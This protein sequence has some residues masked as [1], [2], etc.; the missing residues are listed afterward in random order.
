M[1][2]E[3]TWSTTQKNRIKD[4][5]EIESNKDNDI[6][7]N[8]RMYPLELYDDS[9]LVDMPIYNIDIGLVRFNFRNGRLAKFIAHHCMKNN[10]DDF[11]QSIPEHQKIIQGI[12]LNAKNY[13]QDKVASLE[14]NLL[15]AGQK[16]PALITT[17]GVLWNGNRRCAV[18]QKIFDDPPSSGIAPLVKD[19]IKVC[20]LPENYSNTQLRALEKRLQQTPETK[21]SYGQVNEMVRIQETINKYVE[22]GMDLDNP[23][24]EQKK[25]IGQEA[26]TD[27]FD[28]WK[29]MIAG[30]R[31]VDLMDDW[32]ESRNGTHTEELIGNYAIIEE[33]KA[34]T[35]FE[36][37]RDLLYSYVI[38]F[39][40]NNSELGDPDD[41]YD[42]F[43]AKCFLAF[44][45]LLDK[46]EGEVY[47]AIIKMK[48]TFKRASGDITSTEPGDTTGL[49]TSLMENSPIINNWNEH[50]SK[51]PEEL[52]SL[53][54]E[55]ITVGGV[56]STISEL[57]NEGFQK[58]MTKLKKI[59]ESP[60]K[61]IKDINELLVEILAKPSRIGPQDSQLNELITDCIEKLQEIENINNQ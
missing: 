1:S 31:M 34:S 49:V 11:D 53:G 29:K 12:L 50:M 43:K 57:E 13:G 4:E 59:G 19:R 33:A 55:M 37:T 56:S 21:Q 27:Y 23:S 30:K 45:D 41:M 15:K 40:T 26:M 22:N 46:N 10:I 44:D 35:F 47:K 51:E 38:P 9:S 42:A 52:A 60:S 8:Q 6:N 25:E 28:D 3:N 54:K 39:F 17:S 7:G 14:E 24:N 18:M 5:K 61:I 2:E 16:Y 58:N 32:L 36:A 20:I 48:E